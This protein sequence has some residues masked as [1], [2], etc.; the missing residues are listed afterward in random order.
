V[1]EP[2][3]LGVNNVVLCTFSG[4]IGAVVAALVMDWVIIALSC[5]V[6]A[7]AVVGASGLGQGMRI[8]VFLSLVI[9][10]AFVQ[11]KLLPQARQYDAG[12]R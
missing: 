3:G 12:K 9:A 4:V 2:F 6:G 5:L 7:G 11:T 8:I 10:G 1:A